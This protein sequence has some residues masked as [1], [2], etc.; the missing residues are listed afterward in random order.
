M[1]RNVV[2]ATVCRDSGLLMTTDCYL[3]P[4]NNRAEVAYFVRGTEPR[5]YCTCHTA[6]DYDAEDGGV[7]CEG[8]ACENVTRVGLLRVNRR[9]PMQIY[10]TDSQ[11]T[12]RTM[13]SGV[14]P[15]TEEGTPY[16]ATALGA[17]EY[18]GVSPTQTPYNRACTKHFNTAEQILRR[19]METAD[20][21]ES[22]TATDPDEE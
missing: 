10:V 18:C 8:C 9:F 7:V 3:D 1:D 5:R 4:R 22:E 2:T 16:F 13:P 20:V 21:T 12:C 14:I 15:S 19:H 17:R 6:V 11:Y